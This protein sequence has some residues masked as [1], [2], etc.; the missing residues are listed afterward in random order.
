MSLLSELMSVSVQV[1]HKF[2][3]MLQTSNYAGKIISEEN[4]FLFSYFTNCYFEEFL[5][6]VE[7]M[8]FLTCL[9]ME[10]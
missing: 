10:F 5:P 8:E 9:F 7:F 3:V 2:M 6:F 4:L 1:Q